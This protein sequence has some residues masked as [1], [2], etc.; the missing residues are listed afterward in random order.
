ME[1]IVT[2]LGENSDDPITEIERFIAAGRISDAKS[3]LRT[4]LFA[5]SNS[6]SDIGS[7][8]D[9]IALFNRTGSKSPTVPSVIFRC[10]SVDG[11]IPEPNSTNHLERL[12]VELCET[13]A[14]E[15]CTFLSMKPRSQTYEKFAT[16]QQAHKTISGNLSP[17]T[18]SYGDLQALVGARRSILG[19]LSHSIVRAYFGPH[20]LRELKSSTE[21]LFGS[22]QKLE[23]LDA[24]FLQN[25]EDCQRTVD[26]MKA[27]VEEYPSSL[28]NEYFLKLL[29]STQ[30]CV[31]QFLMN[32]RSQ[33]RAVVVKG[34]AGEDTLAK[35]YPLYEEGRQFHLV[36]PLRNKGAGLAL[37]VNVSVLS[38]S[39][40]LVFDN[41][42]TNLG[43]VKPGDFSVVLEA[44]VTKE[45]SNAEFLL[46]IEWGEI[47]NPDR[48]SADFHVKVLSQ[49]KNV[50]WPSLEYWSPYSTSVAK[51]DSFI[52]RTD[53]VRTL[54]SKLLREVMEPFYITGQKRVGKTSLAN[55]VIDFATTNHPTNDISAHYILWGDV[56]NA[57]PKASVKSLGLNIE[58]F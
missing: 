39:D 9:A 36:I 12:I 20:H 47:G 32:V 18:D 34:W 15:I 8:A 4:W 55:A 38:G 58:R 13:S 44:L 6:T 17:L 24:K 57:D 33:Y 7:I 19:S 48:I 25:F 11:V 14:P 35:R 52:G 45:C 22:L 28:S 10:L 5:Q 30:R 3:A 31:E 1:F 51:G 49:S 40:D 21:V 16:L 29:D 42:A 41:V 53:L 2:A 37:D 56:A 26:D 23:S 43:S 27:M 54:A 50:D 46:H